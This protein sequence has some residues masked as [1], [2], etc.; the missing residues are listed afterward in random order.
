MMGYCHLGESELY[1]N[2]RIPPARM[3]FDFSHIILKLW[4]LHVLRLFFGTFSIDIAKAT[5][6]TCVLID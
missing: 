4:C 3:R 2:L 5:S 6:G 1:I